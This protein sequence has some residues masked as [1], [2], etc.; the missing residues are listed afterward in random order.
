MTLEI[1]NY[2]QDPLLQTQNNEGEI[3]G[4]PVEVSPI[5]VLDTNSG[6]LR[7]RVI[8]SA[9]V[10]SNVENEMVQIPVI[11]VDNNSENQDFVP[12]VVNDMTS[13]HLE[14]VEKPTGMWENYSLN[15]MSRFWYEFVRDFE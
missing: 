14:E 1:P 11:N 10:L 8:P 2:E 15:F 12:G 4:E 13:K 6:L 5:V 9:P 3:E 7:Q